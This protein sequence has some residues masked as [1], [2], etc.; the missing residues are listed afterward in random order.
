MRVMRLYKILPTAAWEA[1]SELLPRSEI[2]AQD[3]FV[4]LSTRE[5]LEETASLH[6]RDQTHLTLVVIDANALEMDQLRWETSR[7]GQIFP[8]IY[9]EVPLTAVVEAQEL[10][11]ARPNEFAFP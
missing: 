11:G 10:V 7:G 8:H 5:Q 2:D 4:H 9:G 6:F 1:R 3:G